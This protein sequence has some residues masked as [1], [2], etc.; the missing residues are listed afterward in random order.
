V[1]AECVCPGPHYDSSRIDAHNVGTINS[2]LSTSGMSSGSVI[3]KKP[4]QNRTLRLILKLAIAPLVSP[5]VIGF[6][7]IIV[8]DCVLIVFVDFAVIVIGDNEL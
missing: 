4:S 2:F 6:V 7:S 3:S 1:R 5:K 8:I